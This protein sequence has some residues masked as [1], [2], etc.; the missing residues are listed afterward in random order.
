[1]MPDFGCRI[2]ELMF[3]PS[4][5]ATAT[6]IA[7]HVEVALARWEPRIDVLSVDSW[8][9][10]EGAIHVEVKYKIR[11]TRAEQAVDLTLGAGG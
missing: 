6:L 10:P 3:A 2:H 11:S 7:D 8:P 9:S 1:M 4:T 5:R